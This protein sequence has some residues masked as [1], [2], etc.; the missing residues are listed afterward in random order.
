MILV[1]APLRIS[2]I[3]CALAVLL[4]VLR[5]IRKSTMEISDLIFWIIISLALIVVAI[6][7]Q[8]AYFASNVLGFEAPSNFIF[9]CGI[10]VLLVRTFTQ[11]QKI[12][13]LKK[14]LVSMSQSDA[15]RRN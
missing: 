11:D 4:F 13:E 7:P 5:R 6:F 15:L 3:I 2:L 10:F 8:I 9:A 14:K 1:N 12:C